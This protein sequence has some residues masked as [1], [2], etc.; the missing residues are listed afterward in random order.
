MQLTRAYGPPTLIP[1]LL[2]GRR[3]LA[4]VSAAFRRRDLKILAYLVPAGVPSVLVVKHGDK[5]N[6]YLSIKI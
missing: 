1:V 5:Y 6:I 3:G 2:V 4:A